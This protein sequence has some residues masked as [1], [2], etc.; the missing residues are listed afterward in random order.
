MN[1]F[2]SDPTFS[3]FNEDEKNEHDYSFTYIC[4]TGYKLK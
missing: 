4:M 1:Y 2:E 3:T